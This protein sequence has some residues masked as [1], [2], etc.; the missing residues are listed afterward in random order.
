MDFMATFAE[1]AGAVYPKRRGNEDIPPLEGKSLL[2]IFAGLTR[3]GHEQLV[4]EWAGNRALREGEWKIAWDRNLK[5]WEL[6]NL[7]R[8]QTE[9]HNLAAMHPDRVDRMKTAWEAWAE[10]TEVQPR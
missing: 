1:A 9:T 2:P 10:M 7:K 3:Q 4:W 8:D 5:A 6:Y